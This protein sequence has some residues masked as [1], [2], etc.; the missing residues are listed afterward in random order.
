MWSSSST[1]R[2]VRVSK[3]KRAWK[4]EYIGPKAGF[5][6]KGAGRL[7]RR[8]I[9]KATRELARRMARHVFGGLTGINTAGTRKLFGS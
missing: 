4:W 1:S 6:Q 7:P 5:H 8:P 2:N 3:G 9:V